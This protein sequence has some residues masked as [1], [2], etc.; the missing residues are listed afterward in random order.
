MPLHK[1]DHPSQQQSS[2]GKSRV[3]AGGSTHVSRGH[4]YHPGHS[5]PSL[6]G[7]L[8]SYDPTLAEVAADIGCGALDQGLQQAAKRATADGSRRSKWGVACLNRASQVRD[9]LGT[10]LLFS[11]SFGRLFC[12]FTFYIDKCLNTEH[13]QAWNEILSLLLSFYYSTA[14]NVRPRQG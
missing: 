3:L 5:R 9:L 12:L 4:L 2:G 11:G 14:L 7:A 1:H 13:G 6:R 10:P 8:A